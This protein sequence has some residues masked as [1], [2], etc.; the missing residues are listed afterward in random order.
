MLEM[1]TV[2]I[3]CIVSEF[4]AK[5]NSLLFYNRFQQGLCKVVRY[6]IGVD[7]FQFLIRLSKLK[8]EE[9]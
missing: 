2:L 8:F 5:F 9:F 6:V 1:T 7:D 4:V 3:D